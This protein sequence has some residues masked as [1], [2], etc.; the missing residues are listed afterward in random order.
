MLSV[1][2]GA[3]FTLAVLAGAVL[4]AAGVTR[5]LVTP[6]ARPAFVAAAA[7]RH[8]N[9]MATTVGC[10][11]LCGRDGRGGREKEGAVRRGGGGGAGGVMGR[12]DRGE[13]KTNPRRYCQRRGRHAPLP[14]LTATEKKF[15]HLMRGQSFFS[16]FFF[17]DNTNLISPL[18]S[19]DMDCVRL[20]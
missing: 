20:S 18:Q 6:G 7:A 8:T 16:S 11:N 17:P 1:P 13:E 2:A 14:C 9:A 3:A 4:V 19:K 15:L 5:P 10:T 12:G